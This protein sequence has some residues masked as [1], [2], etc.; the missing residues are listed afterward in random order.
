MNK[1]HLI[2]LVGMT[3]LFFGCTAQ[4]QLPLEPS[5]QYV[6][7]NGNTVQN[8]SLCD[9]QQ[10]KQLSTEEELSV[11]SG[12]PLVQGASLENTCIIGIAAKHKDSSLCSK[13]NQDQRVLCYALVAET[14]NDPKTC[15]DAGSSE[16]QCLDQYARDKKDVTACD[17]IK[18]IGYKDSCYYNLSN[19]LGDAALCDNIKVI[20]Q[21][22]S[23]YYGIAQRFRDT[24]YCE[25][26][27]NATTKQNCQQ[28]MGENQS[29]QEPP[30]HK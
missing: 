24:S 22:D 14:K 25:K 11:C 23:C 16:D 17:S 27:T 3:L 2:L 6:C 15:V 8:K 12:M 13:I 9:S 21:K 10:T 18:E 26:I 1:L 4:Q 19:Q 20:D 7:P 5:I 28:I 30:I 29:I